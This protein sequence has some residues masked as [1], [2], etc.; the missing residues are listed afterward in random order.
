MNWQPIGITK[1]FSVSL[2]V[3][4]GFLRDILRLD[5]PNSTVRTG[6]FGQAF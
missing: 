3:K 1:L 2:Y 4:S 6:G 5:V